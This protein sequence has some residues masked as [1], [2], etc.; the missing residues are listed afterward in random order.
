MRR[1]KTVTFGELLLRLS[2]PGYERLLQSSTLRASF[3]GGEAN[4]AMSLAAFGLESHFV[5]RL[6]RNAIGDAA[7]RALRAEGVDVSAIRR[8]GERLGLYFT[9]T[10]A[11]QRPSC[12]VY[13]RASSAFSELAPDD[14]SWP[15]VLRDASWF[16]TTGITPAIGESLVECTRA[17]LAAAHRAG[18]R[19]SFD[20][21]YRSKLWT[22]EEA[23]RVILPLLRH[24]HV[25]IANEGHLTRVLGL[26]QQGGNETAHPDLRR[27]RDAAARAVS[28]HGV[29]LVAI[30][31]RESLSASEN[32]WSALL[33][34][35]A[36]GTMYRGPR[37]VVQLVDRIGG[38]DAFAAGLVHSLLEGRSPD[39]AL[40]FAIAAGAL[41]LTVVGDFNR[42]SVEEIERLA[43]G[44]EDGRVRR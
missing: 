44:H 16:H 36:T 23:R 32:G 31:V 11:S 7:I 41:K 24:V 4:V 25:L 27:L 38:G 33:Y 2:A 17:A 6:P 22:E 34:D 10:G 26:A 42:V 9:E 21:N 8:G 3:G 12:V 30:T 18:A 20:V 35:G 40:R 29:E 39:D 14:V 1:K 28:E 19:V 13:D 15:D 43:A 37:Y 5:T